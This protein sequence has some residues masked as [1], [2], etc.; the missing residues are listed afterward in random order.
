[1][2]GTL[3]SCGRPCVSFTRGG[4]GVVEFPY[5]RF[6][7]CRVESFVLLYTPQAMPIPENIGAGPAGQNRDRVRIPKREELR[8]F[9]ERVTEG[10]ELQQ[11]WS[12][13]SAE[14]K[15]S[16]GLYSRE[17]DWKHIQQAGGPDA[18]ARF[19][20][21]L[22]WIKMPVVNGQTTLQYHGGRVP[23]EESA[24]P[25]PRHNTR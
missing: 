24:R 25:H 8:A 23:R 9:W 12:Q 17:V 4:F 1:V 3:E 6:T 20:R 11:L 2:N 21:H 7:S 15:E 18:D 19:V 10:L 5:P 13:F 14:A 22:I 16:Y